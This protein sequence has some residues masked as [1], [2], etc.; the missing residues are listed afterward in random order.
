MHQTF[1][2]FISYYPEYA[3]SEN[4]DFESDWFVP[5]Y[6]VLFVPPDGVRGP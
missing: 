4:V 2:R 6:W 3:I 5:A 1:L